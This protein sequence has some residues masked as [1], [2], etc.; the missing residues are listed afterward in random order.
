MKIKIDPLDPPEEK[1]KIVLEALREGKIILYPTDTVYGIGANIFNLEAV[2][3]IYKIKKRPHNKPLSVC[4]SSIDQIHKIAHLN[5]DTGKKL[6]TIFPGPFT[7]ILKKKDIVNPILTAGGEKI[8]IRIP[9]SK[10]CMELSSKFPITT[11]SAN[12]SGKPIPESVDG[13]WKQFI[14][15]IDLIIDAGTCRH[16]VHSTVI[17]MTVSPPLI[18]RKGVKIP[19]F[20]SS[21]MN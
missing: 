16:G 8:G 7:V 1:I 14:G 10:I 17:D 2:E 13:V 20:Y 18:L 11:T 4:V 6:N 15:E 9:E 12:I 5:R 21:K 3:R 19:P